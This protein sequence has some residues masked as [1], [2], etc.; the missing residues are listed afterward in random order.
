MSRS[1]PWPAQPVIHEVDTWVW[2]TALARRYQRPVTLADVPAEAWD[3]VT[4]PGID[5]IWLMGVW[6]R[7]PVGLEIALGNDEL[8]AAFRAA[9]PDLE[10]G[11]VVGSPYC[12]RNYRVD[13]RLGGP[14][15]LA[16]ARAL[17]AERGIRLVLDYVPN[18]VAPDHPWALRR[19]ELFIRGTS[20]DLARSPDAFVEVGGAV[21]ARGRDPFFPPWPDVLQLNAFH[22]EVRQAT[23]EVLSD[24]GDQCDGLR[25]D[26]AM[27][28][29]TDVF[30]ATWAERAGPA[31]AE[32]FWPEVLR[33][34]RERHPHL[35]F[36]A[37]AYW[38]REWTLQRQGFD[39]CYD[40][41]LYDRLLGDADGVRGHLRAGSD[42][43]RKLIRFIENHDEPRAA[44]TLSPPER[45]R[46][47]TVA[48]ATLPG[49]TLWHEGQ[50]DGRRVRVPVFLG[51]RPD[52]PSD[53]ELRRFALGLLAAIG[54]SGLRSG[55]WCLSETT[56][57]PDNPTHRNLLA[58]T[59]EKGPERQLVILNLSADPAQ[60]R[61]RL[62]WADLRS[63]RWTLTPLLDE[64]P[65]DSDPFVRDGS[66]MAD[67]GL[68]VDLPAWG[69][70]LV[71]VEP[72]V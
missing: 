56:G 13:A 24:I 4:L 60:G 44:S 59:W 37:E 53:P 43:Q 25:C 36:V 33:R 51:R 39:Y 32:E 47:A 52:E 7:S 50:F 64:D 8:R 20:D 61:V 48:I 65:Y 45:L 15:A 28:L 1:A 6:E 58:W 49:A 27:L 30:A 10:P 5:A 57:W 3:E 35:L 23:V 34:V 68:F 12:V 67:V 26:M 38:D 29:L 17:L 22:P 42:Y 72:S 16:A 54:R 71:A 46:A 69:W 31:P 21:L 55:E 14:D 62:P 41:R 2:L 63:H 19:P 66:E 11:D 70:H 9:L 40:K 18:H